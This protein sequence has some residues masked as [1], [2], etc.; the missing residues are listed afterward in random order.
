MIRVE[1]ICLTQRLIGNFADMRCLHAFT[2]QH[3]PGLNVHEQ[4]QSQKHNS[5]LSLRVKRSTVTMYFR[6]FSNVNSPLVHAAHPEFGS[7]CSR[8]LF[9]S[10]DIQNRPYRLLHEPGYMS[11]IGGTHS[12]FQLITFPY[13]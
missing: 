10:F 9:L 8:N 2:L 12:N 5:F 7:L 4:K 1:G 13:Q 3:C 6:L 11:I